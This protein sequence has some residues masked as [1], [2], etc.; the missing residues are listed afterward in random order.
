MPA[1]GEIGPPR[2]LEVG[3]EEALDEEVALRGQLVLRDLALLQNASC[4]DLFQLGQRHLEGVV[5][6][7][8][9]VG[10]HVE[11][12][13]RQPDLFHRSGRELLVDLVG[14]LEA[15]DELRERDRARAC[16]LLQPHALGEELAEAVA[17]V[18]KDH[19]DLALLGEVPDAIL[20]VA[21]RVGQDLRV[22]QPVHL[23]ADGGEAEVADVG[24]PDQR[25][26]KLRHPIV[27]IVH[28]EGILLVPGREEQRRAHGRPLDLEE[29]A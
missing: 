1:C 13:R 12:E 28:P 20:V 27:G 9:G 16:W 21:R 3:A 7:G 23:V 17:L 15:R 8:D 19:L 25:L 4:D 6:L 26:E 24:D 14:A 10:E 11:G 18:K 22:D 2:G 29:R 5:I